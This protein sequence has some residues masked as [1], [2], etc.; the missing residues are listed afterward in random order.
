M[1][2]AG[3]MKVGPDFK[4]PDMD[5]QVRESY[6]HAL[7]DVETGESIDR[8]WIAFNNPE[9]DQVVK[10]VL[11]NNLDIR[12]ALAVISELRAYFVQ[13]R[14]DRFPNLQ[15]QGTAG[16][17]RVLPGIESDVYNLSLPASFEIDL[18]GRLARAEEAALASLTKTEENARVIAQTIVS[19]AITVYFQIESLERRIQITAQIIENYRRNL[20]F[21]ER[22]YEGG[23]TSIL[24]LR[25]ARRILAQTESTL[26]SLR[27]ELGIR[28]QKLAVLSGQYPE[29]RSA[30][31]QPEDYFKL[32]S[33]I[34]PGLPSDLLLRRPDIRAAEATLRALNAKIGVAKGNRF[35]RITL[36]GSFGY[37]STELSQLFKPA[38]SLWDLAF[39]ALSPIFDAGRL[40]AGQRAAEAQFQQGMADYAKTVLTAFSEVEGALLTREEQL[41]KRK[42][43]LIFLTEAKA[44]QKV[45]KNRYERGLIDYLTVLDAQRIRF[46]AEE[47]LVLVELAIL[48]NRVTLHRALGGG[49]GDPESDKTGVGNE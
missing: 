3:C 25:Q 27:Q 1:L 26:P 4:K 42:K 11:S 35:P 38:S 46:Q 40:K 48:S 28:Q 14:A 30:R 45:A 12:K 49:W 47:S 15:L 9:L 19:E 13:S 5:S 6:Q 18:W 2:L 36:T 22:R 16:R 20:A 44:T 43:M 37:S 39:G 32:P 21:V 24:D 29:T 34:P 8:W 41:E 33:P 23:L 31:T 10:N 7:S 17:K